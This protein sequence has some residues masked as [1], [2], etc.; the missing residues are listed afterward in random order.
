MQ[1]SV[2]QILHVLVED[3]DAGNNQ[4]DPGDEQ[5]LDDDEERDQYERPEERRTNPGHEVDEKDQDRQHQVDQVGED[6]RK[7]DDLPREVDLLHQPLV[8]DQRVTGVQQRELEE[9]PGQESAEN[10]GREVGDLHLHHVLDDDADDGDL[11]DGVDEGP[12]EPQGGVLVAH[13]EVPEHQ[14]PQQLPEP[15]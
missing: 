5:H 1:E 11:D 15:V 7:R 12:G 14:D 13:L 10:V 9:A 8:D 3:A 2:H 6:Q 4:R